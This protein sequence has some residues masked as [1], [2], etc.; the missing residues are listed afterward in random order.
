MEQEDPLPIVGGWPGVSTGVAT[1]NSSQQ[2]LRKSERAPTPGQDTPQRSDK[3]AKQ[4]DTD[5]KVL[6]I[7]LPG[8]ILETI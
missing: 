7:I 3:H 6:Y 1:L 8:K 5:S 4:G 2:N